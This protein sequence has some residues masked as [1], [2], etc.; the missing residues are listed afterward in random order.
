MSHLFNEKFLLEYFIS[1]FFSKIKVV[2]WRGSWRVYLKKVIVLE[3]LMRL[4]AQL[5]NFLHENE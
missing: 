5:I 3:I 4:L 1:G 2:P